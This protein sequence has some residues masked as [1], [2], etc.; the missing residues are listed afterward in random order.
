MTR[1][2][3]LYKM[4]ISDWSIRKDTMPWGKEDPIWTQWIKDYFYEKGKKLGYEAEK[5]KSNNQ[6]EGE[7]LVDLCWWKEK[8]K[9]STYWLELILESEWNSSKDEIL[10]DFYKL[11]DIK[12]ALKVWVCSWGEKQM[13]ERLSQTCDY[14]LT[15]RF[16]I[17]EEQYLILNLPESKIANFN[18]SITIIGWLIDNQGQKK[19]LGY[20]S[21]KKR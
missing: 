19:S 8:E 4:I 15:A 5:T 14:I 17:P 12:A 3:G 1:A 16:K 7:Y 2:E 10:Q 20:K 6:G 11:I 9:T 18:D 13:K 21:I